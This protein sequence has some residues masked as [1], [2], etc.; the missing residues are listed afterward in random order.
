MRTRLPALA[1]LGAAL[2]SAAPGRA[3]PAAAGFDPAALTPYFASGPAQAA[4]ARFSAGDLKGAAALFDA[5]AA[6]HPQAGD[7]PPA[8]FLEALA[9]MRLAQWDR[10]AALF[11]ALD[12]TYP[13]LAPY[14][15]LYAARCAL[16]GRHPETALIDLTRVPAGSVLEGEAIMARADAQV[17]LGRHEQ[18]RHTYESYLKQFPGG[19][20][21][22][23]AR[24]RLAQ[25][26]ER[27]GRPAAEVIPLY[28]RVWAEAVTD[29][30]ADE[31][32]ARLAALVKTLRPAQRRTLGAPSVEDLVKRGTRLLER[33]RTK[34]GDQALAAALKARGLTPALECEARFGRAQ[35]AFKQRPRAR[36]APLFQ[37][38]LAPC[39]KA[40]D[41][42]RHAKAL[43]QGGRALV[44]GGD[45]KRALE[46]FAALEREHPTHAYADDARLRRAEVLSDNGQDAEAA[47]LL[48]TLPALYPH[49]DMVGEALWR[50]AW[51]AWRAGNFAEVVRW[52]AENLAKVKR[53]DIWY[54][55]GRAFYWNARARARQGDRKGAQ[56]AYEEAIRQYPLSYYALLSFRRLDQLDGGR[57]AQL[58]RELATAPAAVSGWS[59]TPR[60]VFREAGFLRALELMRLRL[61]AEAQRELAFLGVKAPVRQGA[62]PPASK[63]AEELAWVSALL[64]D[65]SGQWAQSHSIARN[66][67]AG[68]KL[69]YPRGP[70]RLRWEIA[71]PHAFPN[72]VT[73]SAREAGIPGSL[74]WAIARE[75][76]AFNPTI[77]SHAQA[78]GLTQLLVKTAQRFA[79][80]GVR[81]TRERLFDP[82]FNAQLGAQFLAFLWKLWAGNPGLVVA[83]YNAG[84]AAV[85]KWLK[86]RG[87]WSVDEFIEGIPY[88]ETR[89]Y[90]K[91]VLASYFVYSW[92]DG[93]KVPE[94]PLR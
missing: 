25:A 75:E 92:L 52:T 50:L 19:I 34:D 46:L 33:N 68:F 59:F 80:K 58:Q 83:S 79:P 13:L 69:E 2:L 64:L 53:E 5:Y 78:V 35:A 76:S 56:A 38:A 74:L 36:S 72:E 44:S 86:D 1:A 48:E 43:Y 94:L 41:H 82:A 66:H 77:V 30:M 49:G 24:F 29:P 26:L 70:S 65:R 61:G 87:Q 57:A 47:K 55:E 28:R 27:L 51:R 4:M 84:E 18:A 3:Q 9:L 37:A 6:E 85:G 73:A 14:H 32:E 62:P 91:R 22:H 20:R 17:A 54:A 40:K 45:W 11:R 12:H 8:Q 23:A 88:D 67:L 71:Y 93:G 89:G 90:T 15:A 16:A 63:D 60:P 39:Q 81:V 10:A 21:A 31:A 42:D 7:R